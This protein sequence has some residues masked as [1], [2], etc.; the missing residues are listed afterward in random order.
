MCDKM[1]RMLMRVAPFIPFNLRFLRSLERVRKNRSNLSNNVFAYFPTTIKKV[2]ESE[3]CPR[4]GRDTETDIMCGTRL[5]SPSNIN[6][7][8]MRH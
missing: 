3:K 4:C 6:Y 7:E 5:G 8:G 2:A 1:Y